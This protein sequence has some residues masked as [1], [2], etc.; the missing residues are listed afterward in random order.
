[1]AIVVARSSVPGSRFLQLKSAAVLVTSAALAG[2]AQGVILWSLAEVTT[3]RRYPLVVALLLALGVGAGLVTKRSPWQIDRETPRRWLREASLLAPALNGLVLGSGA[4]TR[5]AFWM[6]YVQ[7]AVA[8]L[9]PTI[10]QALLIGATYGACRTMFALGLS[11]RPRTVGTGVSV[12]LLHKRL[13]T[14]LDRGMTALSV[15]FLVC[16]ATG[17]VF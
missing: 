10:W 3:I 9:A 5:I 16:L 1:M 12:I 4:F 7:L 11:R 14:Y 17:R 2:A 8:V 6:F 13:A 15:L